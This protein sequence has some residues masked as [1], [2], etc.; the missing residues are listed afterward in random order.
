[1]S[2][3]EQSAPS[4]DLGARAPYQFTTTHWSVDLA[5]RE[6]GHE[7]AAQALE[8]LC[9]GYWRPIWECAR[10]MGYS[11]DQADDA[12]QGFFEDILK[13]QAITAADPA[14]GKFRTFLLT[15]FQNFLRNFQKHATRE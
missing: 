5:T 8:S 1:M 7:A 10:R 12:V 9:A 4:A 3:T 15:C 6:T 11:P 13:R 14:R 2:P